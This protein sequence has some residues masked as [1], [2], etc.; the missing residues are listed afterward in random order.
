VLDNITLYWL[1]NTRLR[2]D[3]YWENG[4]RGSVIAAAAQ[5]PP[6]SSGRHHSVSGRRLSSAGPGLAALP[7]LVYFNEV[8]EG[9]HFAAE[10]PELFSATRAAFKSL[11]KST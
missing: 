10:Q 6:R 8:D 11:R 7:Q 5:R 3:L 1:T 4:A 2:P 9:G